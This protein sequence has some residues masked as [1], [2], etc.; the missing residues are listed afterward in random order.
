M[1]ISNK[2]ND[3]TPWELILDVIKT[4]LNLW[5]RA[6]LTLNGKCVV[7]QAIMGG[8]IQFLTKAQGMPPHIE[9]ALTNIMSA[10]I[11]GQETRPRIVMDTLRRPIPEGG[12][13]ILDIKARNEVIEI[14]WLKTYLNFSPSHQ[15]WAT[16]MDHIIVAAAPPHSVEKARD[17]Y[18]PG[19]HRSR[20]RGR[21]V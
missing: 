16:I 13:N 21:R 20:V 18:K 12:L 5:E 10:F 14:I 15:K 7:I 1:W 3:Q 8:H 11:W 9:K 17:N 4:K 2:T 19:W 6:H